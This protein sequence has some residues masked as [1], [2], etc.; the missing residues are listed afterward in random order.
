MANSGNVSALLKQL[1]SA[2]KTL[3]EASNKLTEQIKEIETALASYNFGIVTW[4]NLR[5]SSE[6]VEMEKGNN[7]RVTRLERLGYS[8]KNG[9]WGLCASSS[10]EEFEEE[11]EWWLLRDAPRELR[12]LAVDAIPKLLEEMVIR[13]KALTTKVT[14]TT[15]RAKSI[16]HSLQNKQKKG[17]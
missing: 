3:S 6:E 8:K 11:F 1:S 2:S 7:L 4:V 12:I 5:Q 9:K 10:I 13:A 15:D 14:S 17:E 16:A